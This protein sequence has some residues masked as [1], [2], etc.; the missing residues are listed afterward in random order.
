MMK[1]AFTSFLTLIIFLMINN[2]L[3]SVWSK[4]IMGKSKLHYSEKWQII[5]TQVLNLIWYQTTFMKITI[6]NLIL[7]E[8]QICI[9][10]FIQSKTKQEL[11]SK[12]RFSG[13]DLIW[14]SQWS[15]CG[16]SFYALSDVPVQFAVSDQWNDTENLKREKEPL[17]L[18]GKRFI[19]KCLILTT[20]ISRWII[21]PEIDTI[22]T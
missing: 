22:L 17:E 7:T 11:N 9:S 10:L 1:Y 5:T 16:F 12:Q 18:T 4:V 2:L 8:E 6:L 3:N 13:L 19:I 20:Q 15:S 14:I 21:S